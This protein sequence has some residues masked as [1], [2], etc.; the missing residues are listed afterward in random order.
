MEE[1]RRVS[2][3]HLLESK[4]GIKKPPRPGKSDAGR[5]TLVNKK[6]DHRVLTGSQLLSPHVQEGR[7]R[8]L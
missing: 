1:S 7:P 8:G 4:D 2:K 3:R 6:G 5:G